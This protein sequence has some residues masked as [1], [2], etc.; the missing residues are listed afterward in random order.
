MLNHIVTLYLNKT[1][2]YGPFNILFS[3]G[4]RI[5]DILFCNTDTYLKA[6]AYAEKPELFDWLQEY[7]QS[8]NYET[9]A[10]TERAYVNNLF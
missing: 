4:A 2:M 7:R 9:I 8:L 5:I 1:T 3:G 6:Y 10:E